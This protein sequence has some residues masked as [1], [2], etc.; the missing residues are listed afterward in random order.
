M[1]RL[2]T[3]SRYVDCPIGQIHVVEAGDGP[4]L[5]LLHQAPRS[6]DE[7]REFIP[8][9][10]REHRVIAMDMVGFGASVK[11]PAPQ[12]IELYARGVHELLHEIGIDEV[13]LLGHHTGGLVALE[14]AAAAGNGEVSTDVTALVLSSCP[15]TG[16]ERRA[17]PENPDG[18]D[19]ANISD[20]GT[21]L[22]T[23]WNKRR[24]YYPQPSADLLNRFVHD[25]LAYGVDPAEGHRACDRYRIEDRI[26]L[27]TAPTLL[28][29]ASDDPFAMPNIAPLESALSQVT[30]V[31]TTI[32]EHGTVALFERKADEISAVVQPFL[33][34]AAADR[35]GVHFAP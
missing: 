29:G 1:T 6:G 21:H 4:A 18:V 13:S 34:R 14:V 8:L 12:S 17:R 10:A 35:V 9:M 16:P 7:F 32:V 2:N 30:R 20:D 19:K 27:V 15:F 11:V 28:L 24:P 22:N 3:R 26:G 5:L 23:L 25:A 31:E 33:R